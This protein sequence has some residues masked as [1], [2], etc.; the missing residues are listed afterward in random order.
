MCKSATRLD[1]CRRAPCS[2]QRKDSNR[3]DNIFC[4][5]GYEIS[6]RAETRW[7]FSSAAIY[8][9]FHAAVHNLNNAFFVVLSEACAPLYPAPVVYLEIIN[10][11]KSRMN[12][13]CRGAPDFGNHWPNEYQPDKSERDLRRQATKLAALL[14]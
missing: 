2:R 11:A 3:P 10:L 9:L 1:T 8:T 5:T 13:G 4:H 14:S 12:P 7:D 6:Q